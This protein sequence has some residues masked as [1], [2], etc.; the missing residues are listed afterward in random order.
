MQI[1]KVNI[2]AITA[3]VLILAAF[4]FTVSTDLSW[5]VHGLAGLTGLG[6]LILNGVTGGRLAGRLKRDGDHDIYASHKKL[7][8]WFA[9][10]M[11]LTF[12]YGLRVIIEYE[13]PRPLLTSVHGWM[14]ASIAA[15]A[16]TQVVSSLIVKKRRLIRTPHALVGYLL[17]VLVI[18]EAAWGLQIGVAGKIKN[19][20]LIHSV[21]GGIA[22]A[23]V[24][25][26]IIEIRHPTPNGLY[27]AR[28]AAFFAAAINITGCWIIGG[29]QYL[30]AYPEV[31][32]AIKAGPYDW[33]HLIVLETKEHIFLFLPV[34]L[35]CLALM[36]HGM[37]A[38]DGLPDMAAVRKPV[39]MVAF[40]GL[41]LIALMFIMGAIVSVAGNL[42]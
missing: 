27:R 33:A 37:A 38:R 19:L 9:V 11:V 21:L 2:A 35:V 23:A 1:H 3:L 25:W 4:L 5:M 34:I 36:V 12:L 31:K 13:E 14:G 28:L 26:I 7:G 30:T 32:E 20:V 29:Y 22:A 24:A 15:L 6:F 40:L 42:S 41:S 10:F 8:I 18:I 39:L 17:P 16:V